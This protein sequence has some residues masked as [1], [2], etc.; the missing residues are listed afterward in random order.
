MQM[1][2]FRNTLYF[3]ENAHLNKLKFLLVAQ[4]IFQCRALHGDKKFDLSLIAEKEFNS[5]AS[6]ILFETFLL[7]GLDQ[8]ST[9][10]ER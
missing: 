9:E 3:I 4:L 7:T 1:F 8:V 10:R 6:Y 5:F 2:T